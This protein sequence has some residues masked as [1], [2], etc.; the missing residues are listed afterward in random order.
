MTGNHIGHHLY[1][2]VYMFSEKKKMWAVRYKALKGL[3]MQLFTI[4]P[5]NA[6]SL[7]KS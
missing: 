7:S 2:G 4:I 6:K 3:N 1:Q 5:Q